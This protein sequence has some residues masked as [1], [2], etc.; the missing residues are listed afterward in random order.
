MARKGYKTKKG[1][2]GDKK[3]EKKES[4]IQRTGKLSGYTV[5]KSLYN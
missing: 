4:K 1:Y 3:A 5:K 2:Q